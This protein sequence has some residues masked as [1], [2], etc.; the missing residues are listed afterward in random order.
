LRLISGKI[1]RLQTAEQRLTLYTR[2]LGPDGEALSPAIRSR[3]ALD[4]AL[5]LREQGDIDGFVDRLALAI[6]LDPT[7]KEAA[8]LAAQYYSDQVSDPVGKFQLLIDLLYADPLDP[9]VHESIARLLAQEGA[10]AQA[11]RFHDNGIN[12]LSGPQGQLTDQL[13]IERQFL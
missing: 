5:L 7:H 11:K 1:G 10:W 4:D 3:L 12:L 9:N 8:A 13:Y 2:L 6:R